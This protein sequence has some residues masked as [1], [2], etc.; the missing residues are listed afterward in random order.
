M[1]QIDSPA[2]FHYSSASGLEGAGP[3]PGD[4]VVGDN[5]SGIYTLSVFPGSPRLTC[6]T[7]DTAL[8]VAGDLRRRHRVDSWLS[9]DSV[10][11]VLLERHAAKLPSKPPRAGA[12][13]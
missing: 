10:R 12:P 1:P 11:F 8:A 4:V 5:G 3:R 6:P 13:V 7:R 2:V 9:R